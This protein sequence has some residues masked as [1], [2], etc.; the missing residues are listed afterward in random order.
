MAAYEFVSA[1]V[2][3]VYEAGIKPNGDTLFTTQ[4]YRNIA[5]GTSAE[6]LGAV[7]TG[8]ASLCQHTLND[9]VKTQKDAITTN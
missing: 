8:I 5:P 4:T 1:M 2:T 7:C 6:Q 9:V 3:L